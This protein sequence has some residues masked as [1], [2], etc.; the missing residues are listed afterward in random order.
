MSYIVKLIQSGGCDYTI[1]C[2]VKVKSLSAKSMA[3]AKTEVA[4]LIAEEH[5]SPETRINNARIYEVTLAEGLD[6]QKIYIQIAAR[7]M[8][9]KLAEKEA[10][11][12]AELA[13]LKVLY[14]GK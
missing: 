12:L 14:P 3:E 9:A 6:V 13:R 8:E 10:Q 5:D 4:E 11:E 2:G 1:G 7:E